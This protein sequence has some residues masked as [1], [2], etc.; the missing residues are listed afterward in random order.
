MDLYAFKMMGTDRTVIEINTNHSFYQNFIHQV[1]EDDNEQAK[2]ILRLLF[3]SLV[4]AEQ[5]TTSTSQEQAR[6]LKRI[7]TNMALELDDFIQALLQA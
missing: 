5:Q 1:E 7:R 3:S 2:D 4:S 6:M